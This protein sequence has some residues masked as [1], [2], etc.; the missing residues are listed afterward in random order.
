MHICAG[1]KPLLLLPWAGTSS[2]TAGSPCFW[3]D[4]E[5]KIT[6]QVLRPLIKLIDLPPCCNSMAHRHSLSQYPMIN[7]YFQE[8]TSWSH[9][10]DDIPKCTQTKAENYV[11]VV[12]TEILKVNLSFLFEKRYFITYQ[13][14]DKMCMWIEKARLPC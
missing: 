2:T 7:C 4:D 10:I 5:V 12:R 13:G 1:R 6:W 9:L 8:L 14:Q 11:E 3:T